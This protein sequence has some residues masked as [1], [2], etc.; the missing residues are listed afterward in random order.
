MKHHYKA[1]YKDIAA[2]NQLHTVN[3]DRKEDV[4]IWF[5]IIKILFL[6]T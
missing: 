3:F 1:I 5:R 2:R 4:S 6:F